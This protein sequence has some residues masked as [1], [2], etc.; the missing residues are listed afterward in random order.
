MQIV[1]EHF[2]IKKTEE[3]LLVFW[4][5]LQLHPEEM[6]AEELMH[7]FCGLAACHHF[8]KNKDTEEV[9]LYLDSYFGEKTHECHPV[10]FAYAYHVYRKMYAAK[11]IFFHNGREQMVSGLK[12]ELKSDPSSMILMVLAAYFKAVTPEELIVFL[13]NG[14]E[15]EADLLMASGGRQEELA[16]TLYVVTYLQMKELQPFL[17]EW[18][19]TS[20]FAFSGLMLA[21]CRRYHIDAV[22]KYTA[23]MKFLQFDETLFIRE[24]R[25]FLCF[26]QRSNGGFGYLNP[27][28]MDQG[29][30]S[31]KMLDRQY[32]LPSAHYAA[33]TLSML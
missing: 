5:N 11:S 1:E 26:Q 25:E 7:L 32:F 13:E 31:G 2:N 4:K 17:I 16:D 28:A 20:D 22:A 8:E 21:E 9:I 3:W 15:R 12:D 30:V 18:Y 24:G 29:K 6:E 23:I 33:A 27:L 10:L 14:L 19:K